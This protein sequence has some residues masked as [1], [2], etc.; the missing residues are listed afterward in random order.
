MYLQDLYYSCARL[1]N[2]IE[3]ITDNKINTKLPIFSNML[4]NYQNKIRIQNP[5]KNLDLIPFV[6]S[7]II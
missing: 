3:P 1:N 5:A 7:I 2:V 6:E 4:Y